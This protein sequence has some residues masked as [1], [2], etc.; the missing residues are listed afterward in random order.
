[1]CDTNGKKIESLGP[2]TLLTS[3]SADIQ[4]TDAIG[5]GDSLEIDTKC[6]N[7]DCSDTV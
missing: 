5:S 4:T 2:I 1:M 7:S 3:R 6:P